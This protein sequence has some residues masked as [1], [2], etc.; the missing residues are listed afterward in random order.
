MSQ[1]KISTHCFLI[2]DAIQ[3]GVPESVFL[4][5]IR[6]WIKVNEANE[7]PTHFKEGKYWTYDSREAFAK[8][9]PFWTDDQIRNVIKN[10]EKDGA[11][12]KGH[13]SK[14]NYSRTTWYTLGEN[15][16][17]NSENP[18]TITD[19]YNRYNNRENISENDGENNNQDTDDLNSWQDRCFAL[20]KTPG[21]NSAEFGLLK[22]AGLVASYD[23]LTMPQKKFFRSIETKISGLK[24]S[25]K[26][27]QPENNTQGEYNSE[28]EMVDDIRAYYASQRKNK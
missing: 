22:S 19:K 16:Q 28:A 9:F 12:I 18:Q 20:S 8:I 15:P 23:D 7:N 24:V 2:E 21:L 25:A 11:I 10:L 6:H 3:Y 26:I 5:H 14:G 13:F 1:S 17:R 4:Y 27:A